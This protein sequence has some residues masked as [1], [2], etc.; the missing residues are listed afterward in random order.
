MADIYRIWKSVDS[1]Y[2]LGRRKLADARSLLYSNTKK[3]Y[4]LMC[5]A[6]KDVVEESKAAQE[7][8][9][10][11]DIISQIEDRKVSEL[12]QKYLDQL[13]NGDFKKARDTAV[14]ISQ[15]PIIKNSKHS[16]DIKLTSRTENAFSYTVINT[17]N[18]NLIVKRF[19]VYDD[20]FQ[21]GSNVVYPFTIRHNSSMHISFEFES[22]SANK[23]S[24]IFE[25]SEDGIVKT[26]TFDSPITLEV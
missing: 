6:R 22:L 7:Y 13:R 2:I 5:K 23:V 24:V 21:L 15:C 19:A 1:E 25:Y 3:A 14:K 16:V 26:L 8:N 17:S 10:Y 11:C 9:C 20:N 18:K 12:N 4:K